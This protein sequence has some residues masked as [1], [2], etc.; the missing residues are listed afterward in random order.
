MIA[1]TLLFT[2]GV[3][4]LQLQSDLLPV[5]LLW[6]LL[7]ISIAGLWPSRLRLSA[8][9]LL[10]FCWASLHGHWSLDALLPA[11]LEGKSLQAVG[12]VA[13]LP[14]T[15]GRRTRFE[16]RIEALEFEGRV[17]S[18]PGLTRISWYGM[19]SELQ[20]GE[21]WHLLLRLKRPHGMY[22]PGTFDYQGWLFQK[23]IHAT[24][25]V[26]QDAGNQLLNSDIERTILDSWRLSIREMLE[27]S[28]ISGSGEGLLRALVIGDRE[29][30]THQQWEVFRRSGTNHLMAISGLH[31]GIVAGWVMLLGGRLWRLS[32]RLCLMLA[33]PRAAAI[34]ALLAALLYAGL[35]GFAIPALRAL[36]MLLVALGGVIA[37]RPVRPFRGLCWALLVILLF[38]PVAVLSAGFWLSF[39]AVAV[40]L[41]GI[42]GRIALSKSSLYTLFRIQWLVTLGLAPVLLVWDFGVSPIA[43]LVNLLAVPLF[44]LLLVPLAL[45]STLLS[46]VVPVVGYPLLLIT[47][48]LLQYAASALES[49]ANAPF[50]ML[51]APSLPVWCWIA[52]VVAVVLAL[53]PRGVPG[54]WLGMLLVVPLVTHKPVP[55]SQGEVELTL[56]DVGQGLSVVIRTSEHTLLY[57]AGPGFPSG[58]NTGDAVVVPYLRQLGVTSLDKVLVSNGDMDHSGGLGAVLKQ[59]PVSE[60]VSGEPERLGIDGVAPCKA[61]DRWRWD[62]VDFRILHPARE[63]YWEGNNASCVLLIESG[64]ERMLLTG[65]IEREVEAA[66]VATVP[67]QIDADLVV[68]PHHGSLTSSSK[69]FIE[70]V[71]ADL[72]LVSS[73]Y[74]NRYHFPKKEVVARWRSSGSRVFNTAESGALTLRMGKD[75]GIR[76]VVAYRNSARRYWMN[77]SSPLR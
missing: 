44:S 49:V 75:G 15:E 41:G 53:L 52:A 62:G 43:P 70:A 2:A 8:C 10:G 51:I 34:M 54:R 63:A 50:D 65:D 27:K 37:A 45:F 4:V 42:G 36:V 30:I 6:S 39:G 13:S 38:D 64:G 32:P 20:M 21:R 28:M 46:L 26:R 7:L 56:L 35:A 55:L 12:V 23:G 73:G 47:G 40:I 33:A 68:I 19:Q 60:I 25:Y 24:G 14:V 67:E 57:D 66:L 48:Q 9:F 59:L 58:F 76:E 22:N 31:I 69:P 3:V 5:M 72:A 61:G 11:E 18:S 17:V 29:G 71:S 16:F 74:R 1:G 77:S